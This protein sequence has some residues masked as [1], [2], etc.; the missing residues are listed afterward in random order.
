MGLVYV[1]LCQSFSHSIKFLSLLIQAEPA[2]E[3]GFSFRHPITVERKGVS[4]TLDYGLVVGSNREVKG[5]S[6]ENV[7]F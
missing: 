5:C 4:K 6:W 3:F 1:L 7:R 2:E